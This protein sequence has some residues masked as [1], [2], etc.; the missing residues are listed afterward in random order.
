MFNQQASRGARALSGLALTSMLAL[1]LAACGSSEGSGGEEVS[2]LKVGATPSLSGLGLRAAISE[3]EFSDRGLTVTPVANKSANDAVPQL[4]NGELHFAQMDT[5]TFLQA[6]SQG[7]PIKI[8][9]PAGEQSTNGENDTM[10]A[11]SVVAPSGS[12]IGS[13]TDLVGERVGVSAI[14][15][16]TWMNIR[17]LVDDAGGDSS[18]IEF[19]E[20]PPAQMVDLVRQGEVAAATPNEPLASGA[21]S[22]GAVD[23]VHSTDVPGNKGV[24][25]AVYA[26]SEDFLAQNPETV[27]NFAE[28]VQEAAGELNGN[29]EMA[30]TIAEEELDFSPEQ[31]ENA[32]I[33][34]FGED[35]IT[36]EELDKVAEL[37]VKYEILSEKPDINEL[38]ANVE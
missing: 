5:V 27:K 37:A 34:T 26:V 20:V 4:L 7:L 18:N 23:L 13:I 29:R 11:A 38:L 14:K 9:A 30:T 31:M 22:N 33:Q 21:I 16:Q 24:P 10:S 36:P 19:V 8:A 32:F 1:S 12:N 17:A 3:G 6:R 2:D 35:S 28:S 25:S 15:T